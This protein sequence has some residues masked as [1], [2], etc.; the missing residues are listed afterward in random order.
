MFD[1]F[2]EEMERGFIVGLHARCEHVKSSV[3][4]PILCGV[5]NKILH[6]V[7]A[8]VWLLPL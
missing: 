5:T 4:L 2:F 7:L 6:N 3:L 1:R 8:I